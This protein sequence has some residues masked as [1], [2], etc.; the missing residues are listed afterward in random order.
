MGNHRVL[1]WLA[2]AAVATVLGACADGPADPDGAPG[3]TPPTLT[4]PVT[5][6]PPMP[7]PVPSPPPGAER[8]IT[9]EVVPGVE[10]GCLLLHTDEDDFL[11]LGDHDE[12]TAGRTATVR[13][14]PDPD[15]LTYCQQGTPFVILEVEAP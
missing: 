1:G 8:T 4:P 5:P 12:L 3:P 7:S 6:H 14:Y 13:G 15:L 11:L 2:A 10:A 9:G